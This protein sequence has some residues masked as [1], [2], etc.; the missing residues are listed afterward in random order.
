MPNSI[1][2][3]NDIPTMENGMKIST[4]PTGIESTSRY[5]NGTKWLKVLNVLKVI[6]STKCVEID[7]TGKGKLPVQSMRQSL[8]KAAK[9]HGF[10]PRIHFARKEDV[11]YIWT[12]K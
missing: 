9:V 4:R 1:I 3:N 6:D 11:L 10:Q 12:N 2:L 7:V 8:R 5:Y